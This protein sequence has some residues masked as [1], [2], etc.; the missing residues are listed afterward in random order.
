[1]KKMKKLEYQSSLWDEPEAAIHIFFA[2]GD[3]GS[4]PVSDSQAARL[5]GISLDVFQDID[6]S[7]E[8]SRDHEGGGLTIQHVCNWVES[9]I[10][11]VAAF[12][13][14][15]SAEADRS[16]LQRCIS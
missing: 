12:K 1:M 13:R 7:G 11:N 16:L 8:G 6:A 4:L 9:R 15:K 10:N 5:M 2:C 3:I 14:T